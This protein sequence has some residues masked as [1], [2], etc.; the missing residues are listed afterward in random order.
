MATPYRFEPGFRHHF[1]QLIS[2]RGVEQ[3]V[4]RRAHNPE[5]R[6]FKS[7]P[8]NQRKKQSKDCFFLW[9][10]S[11]PQ[12]WYI[13]TARSV[14]HIISPIGAV[15]HHATA[16]ITLRL[17]D[18]QNF[19]LMICNSCEIDDI[20]G[21]ALMCIFFGTSTQEPVPKKMHPR[22]PEVSS[23]FLRFSRVSSLFQKLNINAVKKM[24]NPISDCREGS[25]SKHRHFRGIFD[26]IFSSDMPLFCF[27]KC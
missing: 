20:Q 7:P 3:L 9:L 2:Y 21:F 10:L 6:R 23:G 12:A 16:C 24:Q 18:I 22:K 15:S 13:I 14:V 8:R 4:A 26:D 25:E 11:K 27:S 5:V 19:V 17:D 1:F